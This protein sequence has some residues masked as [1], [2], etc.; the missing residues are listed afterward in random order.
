M[1]AQRCASELR[2][3]AELNPGPSLRHALALE[4][5]WARPG[6]GGAETGLDSDWLLR[7]AQAWREFWQSGVSGAVGWW[8]GEA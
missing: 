3:A 7:T 1:A 8:L 4:T 6:S 2:S 5:G